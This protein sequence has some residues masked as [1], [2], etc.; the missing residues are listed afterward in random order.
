MQFHQ[1]S[2]FLL[3]LLLFTLSGCSS[4]GSIHNQKQ[5]KAQATQPPKY[6]I[7]TKLMSRP[8]GNIS[9][10]LAFSGGGTRAAAFAYGVLQELEQTSITLQNRRHSLID[11]VDIISAVSGG[12]FIA[13]Y[14][15]L[16]GK[17]TFK[18]FK[19]AMLQQ[20][21]EDTIIS[22]ILSPFSWFLTT[23][24]TEIA[25]QIYNNILFKNATFQDLNHPNQPLI[26]I[27]ASDL[28]N[29]VRFSFVQEYFN[30]ICSD[31]NSYPIARAVAASAAVPVAFNPVIIQNFQPCNNQ[32]QQKL[33]QATLYAQ[34]NNEL[35]QATDGLSDYLKTTYPYLHLVDGGITDNLGLRAIYE[36]VELSGGARHFASR[37]GKPPTKWLVVISVDA[38]TQS[39]PEFRLS[40]KMPSIKESIDAMTDIQIHRYNTST[41]T[42]FSETLTKWS[43]ELSTPDHQVTPFFIKLNFNQLSTPE[44][45]MELNLIPTSLSLSE[46]EINTL[47]RAGRS[48]LRNN[49]TFQNLLHQLRT[50]K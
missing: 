3:C 28:G 11:E 42:L 19:K 2:L 31:I 18:K 5:Q 17:K 22:G 24:R 32:A 44:Q 49:P 39:P 46:P 27:N 38:S 20:N 16:H 10:A 35:K 6:A 13:A 21:I 15:G 33:Q 47:I 25:V 14:Y 26:L 12:S 9:L 36:A 40:N 34:K 43:T 41:L 30:L 48:L 50:E 4:Y 1:I 7:T 37:I 8:R 23:G 45:R 29:G